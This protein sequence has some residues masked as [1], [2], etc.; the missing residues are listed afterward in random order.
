MI[1]ISGPTQERTGLTYKYTWVVAD[2]YTNYTRTFVRQTRIAGPDDPNEE[3]HAHSDYDN[4]IQYCDTTYAAGLDE[5]L[6]L[7]LLWIG[8]DPSVPFTP[9][10]RAVYWYNTL[11]QGDNPG[12]TQ[13][14][15]DKSFYLQHGALSRIIIHHGDW[16]DGIETFYGGVSSGLRGA[17]GGTPSDLTLQKGEVITHMGGA[18]ANGPYI[19]RFWVKTNLRSDVFGGGANIKDDFSFDL[20]SPN[21]V[22]PGNG[23]LGYLAGKAANNRIDQVRPAWLKYE[24]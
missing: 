23:R 4:R 5:F 8:F 9:I 15:D 24:I 1:S 17:R 3:Q 18:G 22:Q 2:K 21:P 19:R 20:G 13:D 14:W 16:V 12:G 11:A 7:S 10:P 6:A